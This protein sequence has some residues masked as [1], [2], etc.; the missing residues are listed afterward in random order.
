MPGC[1]PRSRL[2]VRSFFP[3]HF[4]GPKRPAAA[5]LGMRGDNGGLLITTSLPFLLNIIPLKTFGQP[6]PH[7]PGREGERSQAAAGGRQDRVPEH[8]REHAG[9]GTR[10]HGPHG[11]SAAR[12]LGHQTGGV[13]VGQRP[14]RMLP[15]PI[16]CRN[17]FFFFF[18]FF[19]FSLCLTTFGWFLGSNQIT[20]PRART[21]V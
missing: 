18:L 7:R 15:L 6:E 19:F 11:R 10:H 5:P 2:P 21:I 3:N 9:T 20:P 17:G 14:L 4:P 13:P 16:F 1:S 12:H 8:R